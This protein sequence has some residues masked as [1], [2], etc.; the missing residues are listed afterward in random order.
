M[1]ERSD[2]NQATSRGRLEFLDGLRAGAAWFV[3]VHHAWLGAF[4]TFPENTG[5]WAVGWLRWGHLPVSLFIVISGFSL[6]LAPSRN[7]DRTTAG[8]ADFFRR[9]AV[10]IVPP[11]WAALAVS[12]LTII[13]YTGKH[14]E[15]YVTAKT[16]VVYGLLLQ[17]TFEAPV[18][19]GA[20][21]SIAVEW[22][23][24][25]F[26]PLLLW[27]T[28]RWGQRWMVAATT[29]AVVG[30]YVAA[31]EVGG[32]FEKFLRFSPQY[33]LLFVFG[34]VAARALRS[35]AVRPGAAPVTAVVGSI[36]VL[37]LL[38][39]GSPSSLVEQFFWVDLAFGFVCAVW[40]FAMATGSFPRASA[41]LSLRPM[42]W[43]GRF[44]YS[45]YLIHVPVLGV[46]HFAVALPVGGTKLQ[47]FLILV[48][49][50]LP[51]TLVASY[52]L[53]QF[54][55]RPSAERTSTLGRKWV[56]ANLARVR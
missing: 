4:G 33:L 23:I 41:V 50:G 48:L 14:S 5:P 16:V 51:A 29:V 46:T 26:F 55:E 21:W 52:V 19:N 37:L 8:A 39:L 20:F 40:L 49:V 42:V 31:T 28:R 2:G 53:Y 7:D 30:I 1:Y 13:L 43:L 45:T 3:V 36:A 9:R 56:E 17:D 6:T 25:F 35:S 54:V 12:C 11:Y 22:H 47:E 32:F 18:P 34:V 10:R 24:Y 27:M 38:C 15:F 44:S